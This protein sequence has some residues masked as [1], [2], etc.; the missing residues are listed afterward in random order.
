MSTTDADP[1]ST[2]VCSSLKQWYEDSPAG[3][4]LSQALAGALIP[5]LS[6]LFGYNA[7]ILGAPDA[8]DVRDSVRTRLVSR[9]YNSEAN[10]V[11]MTTG[12]VVADVDDLPF[13]SNS[14]DVVIAVNAL[15]LTANPHQALR[16]I[17]RVLT[18]Q[19]VLLLA[20]FSPWSLLSLQRRWF[21]HRRNLKSRFSAIGAQR[22]EDW[23]HLLEFE[24]APPRF[25]LQMPPSP[26]PLLRRVT[27]RVNR[28]LE[29]T[30][31]PLG[32]VYLITAQ[33]SV[34]AHIR[35]L[36]PARKFSA[37]LIPVVGQPVAS[38][39]ARRHSRNRDTPRLRPVK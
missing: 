26:A 7:L 35:K 33:K 8:V 20:G 3:R 37:R 2:D 27:Q 4:D 23:L 21:D 38:S 14:I 39:G 6:L 1:N 32:G 15:D 36:N 17:H 19:G 16:E 25:F 34:S 24:T 10:A 18:P 11:A 30:R 5:Q 28:T 29:G 31:L 22:V 13:E 9:V 12:A